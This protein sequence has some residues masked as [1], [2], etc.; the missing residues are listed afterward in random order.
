[1]GW[2]PSGEKAQKVMRNHSTIQ[3]HVSVAWRTPQFW[4]LWLVLWLNVTAGIGILGMASPMLQEI[5]AGK[6][7]SQDLSWNELKWRTVEADCDDGRRI[8][9]PAQ[10]V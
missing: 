2:H 9:R 8:H 1:M 4:L 3:V 6:L 10:F 5:F 7:L